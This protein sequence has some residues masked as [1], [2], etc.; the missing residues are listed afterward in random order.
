MNLEYLLPFCESETQKK[1]VMA[2][3]AHNSL[4]DAAKALGVHHSS[5]SRSIQTIK[6]RAAAQGISPDHGWTH[7]VPPGWAIKG[8]SDLYGPDGERKLQW[9]KTDKQKEDQA[10]QL[11]D[12]LEGLT[13]DVAVTRQVTPQPKKVDAD[14]ASILIIGDAHLGMYSW[15]H[16]SGHDFD[17][18]IA[19]KNNMDAIDYLVDSAPNSGTGVLVDVGDFM[20]VDDWTGSTPQNSNVLDVDS[21]YPRVLNQAGML[22]RYCVDKMLTKFKVVKV[23]IAK[24][25]HNPS[26]A[27]ALSYLMK[28]YYE[29]RG[30]KRVEVMETTG[31]FHFI[32]HGKHLIGVNHGDKIKAQELVLEMAT[33]HPGWSEA[34]YRRWLTGHIHHKVAVEIRG[35]LVESYNSL[36]PRDGWHTE[37]GYGASQTMEML[38][39][40][41]T[42][43]SHSKSIY[44]LPEIDNG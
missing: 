35:C 2:A 41:K 36:A 15:S 33:N 37:H 24:G 3:V 9:I 11:K 23:V 16:E 38:T 40:H 30:E 1:N 34:K 22:L 20:H 43:G 10:R 13:Q 21:R 8:T 7:E 12:F 31:P 19:V 25:N 32:E 17:V 42:T 29:G 28:Y 4:R 6:K 18:D 27:V 44:T 5:V 39:L 26:S 14:L